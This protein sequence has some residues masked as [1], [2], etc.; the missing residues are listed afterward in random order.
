MIDVATTV[1]GV[2][3]PSV[4]FIGPFTDEA[5]PVMLEPVI[6]LLPAQSWMDPTVMLVD[7]EAVV[8]A[9]VL[10]VLAPIGPVM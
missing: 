10:A 1:F 5:V 8:N 2:V 3:A 6:V 9:P 7:A 4:P